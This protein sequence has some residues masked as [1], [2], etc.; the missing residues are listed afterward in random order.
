MYY[1]M[2]GQDGDLWDEYETLEEAEAACEKL[3]NEG[4]DAWI[5]SDEEEEPADL[6]CG[7]DPYEGCYSYDC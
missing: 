4:E 1:V 5:C 3:L 6:E 7:F 2:F